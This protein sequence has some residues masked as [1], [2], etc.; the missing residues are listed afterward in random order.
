[1]GFLVVTV[2]CGVRMHMARCGGGSICGSKLSM[3][4]WVVLAARVY[5]S[6][7]VVLGGVLCECLVRVVAGLLWGRLW[8]YGS[9]GRYFP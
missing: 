2:I 5:G 4:G 6:G 8:V 3:V 7:G 1:M 9:L